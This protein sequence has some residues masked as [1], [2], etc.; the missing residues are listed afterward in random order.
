MATR[1]ITVALLGAPPR[2]VVKALSVQSMAAKAVRLLAV[3]K[4]VPLAETVAQSSY[5]GKRVG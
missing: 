2:M 5:L 1:I 3:H 4:G